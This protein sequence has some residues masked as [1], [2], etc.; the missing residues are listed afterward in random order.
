MSTKKCSLIEVLS[1]FTNSVSGFTAYRSADP[2]VVL[3]NE[4]V[5]A[6]LVRDATVAGKSMKVLVGID[7]KGK[8]MD[9][10]LDNL[11]LACPPI[12]HPPEARIVKPGGVG[13]GIVVTYSISSIFNASKYNAADVTKLEAQVNAAGLLEISIKIKKTGVEQKA[14]IGINQNGRIMDSDFHFVALKN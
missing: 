6:F 12:C 14:L 4:N 1:N 8:V 10:D 11:A 3:Q 5:T 9:S 2:A 13:G 7:N